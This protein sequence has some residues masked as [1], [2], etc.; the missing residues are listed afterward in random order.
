MPKT[1]FLLQGVVHDNHMALL[2]SL[3]S[4]PEPQTIV[5]STAFMTKA[6]LSILQDAIEPIAES[7]TVFAGIRNGI[8]SAQA[9]R[10]SMDLGCRTYT[11]DTG[12]RNI[13]FH[14]KVYYARN[15]EEARIVVGSANLTVG[16]LI[17][18][19]E[20]SL[21][22]TLELCNDSD[23]AVYSELES[24]FQQ[25]VSEYTDHVCLISDIT[26]IRRSFDSGRVV[27]EMADPAPE[28]TM[29]SNNPEIDVLNRMPL[30]THASPIRSRRMERSP[31]DTELIGLSDARPHSK[32]VWQSN[33]LTRRDLN[34]PTGPITN[35]T[36]S[37]LF[38]KGATEEIDQRRYF[39]EDVFPELPWRID[40]NLTHYERVEA[41]FRIVISNVDYGVFN[42]QLSHNNRTDTPAYA[43]RNSMTQ[44]H[45][46][47]ARNLIAKEDLLDRTMYLYKQP[48]QFTLEID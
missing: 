24:I 14:P 19:V 21:A 45:W 11:V 16:G 48:D 26:D 13:V 10:L 5:L 40:P 30:K 31:E 44:L 33:P 23:A 12:S 17:S 41:K 35:P 27:D 28:P 34:I 9:L 6:G 38:S 39:R 46:G 29:Q 20:A 36:G 3:L 4:L 8:T 7:T 32:L 22:L 18:N 25:L 42:L 15:R 2:R 37:M 43:Q 47:E 1:K